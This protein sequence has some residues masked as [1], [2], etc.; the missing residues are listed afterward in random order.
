MKEGEPK[1][2][3]TIIDILNEDMRKGTD[4][5]EYPTVELL[6]ERSGIPTGLFIGG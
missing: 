5:E 6:A 3:P 4:L 1:P 2:E